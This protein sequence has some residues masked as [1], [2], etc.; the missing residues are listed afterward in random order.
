MNGNHRNRRNNRIDGWETPGKYL[1]A[2]GIERA[3]IFQKWM[4]STKC[5]FYLGYVLVAVHVLK[6]DNKYMREVLWLSIVCSGCYGAF[7]MVERDKSVCMYI[8]DAIRSCC[9]IYGCNIKRYDITRSASY[10]LR[11]YN[12]RH[13]SATTYT[14]LVHHTQWSTP[15]VPRG[16]QCKINKNEPQWTENCATN[17]SRL[18]N[19]CRA[20]TLQ[21]IS[22]DPVL[23]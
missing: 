4:S 10:V 11:W 23:K 13:W 19:R 21:Y 22:G 6:F 8:D 2:G 14:T 9:W 20:S 1:C 17:C 15:F 7:C 12:D 3:K 5:M 18:S 16:R